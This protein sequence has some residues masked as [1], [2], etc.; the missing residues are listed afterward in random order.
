[1]QTECHAFVLGLAGLGSGAGGRQM[2]VQ[3]QGM[4]SRAHGPPS[5]KNICTTV[6]KSQLEGQ[7]DLPAVMFMVLIDL[8]FIMTGM[9]QTNKSTTYVSVVNNSARDTVL[10][11]AGCFSVSS[12]FIPVI[13]FG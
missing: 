2:A 9:R 6:L 4:W 10:Q 13:Q 5:D 7:M 3:S 11:T 12:C 8:R 1:M